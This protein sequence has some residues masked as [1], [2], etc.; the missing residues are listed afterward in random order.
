MVRHGETDHNKTHRCMGQRIDAPLNNKG[1]SQA[2]QLTEELSNEKV[3]LILVSPMKRARETAGLLSG[4][5][6]AP[7]EIE[8]ALKERDYGDLSGNT[9]AEIAEIMHTTEELARNLDHEQKYDYR[10]YGGESVGDVKERLNALLNKLRDEYPQT[11][12]LLVTHGGIIRLMHHLY[13]ESPK[14]HHIQPGNASI[15]EFEI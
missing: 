3:D 2:R 4:T 6:G 5:L 13:T 1:L 8:D 15:H 10:P 11:K 7:V 9:W 14:T 12:L